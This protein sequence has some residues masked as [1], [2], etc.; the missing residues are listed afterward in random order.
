MFLPHGSIP[1]PINQILHPQKRITAHLENA[2]QLERPG[3]LAGRREEPE[4]LHEVT[5]Q[6]ACQHTDP[7]TLTGARLVVR[8]DLGERQCGFDGKSDV[9]DCS[10]VEGVEGGHGGEDKFEGY[11]GDEEAEEELPVSAA[12]SVFYFPNVCRRETYGFG[13]RHFQKL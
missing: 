7:E 4:H 3:Y 11:E 6:P 1:V 10:G 9:A 13:E 12:L 2:A 5:R 8:V